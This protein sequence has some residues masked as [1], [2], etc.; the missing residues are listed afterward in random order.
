MR[1]DSINQ[2]FPLEWILFF[3]EWIKFIQGG[4]IVIL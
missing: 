2:K 1:I 4:I 3:L